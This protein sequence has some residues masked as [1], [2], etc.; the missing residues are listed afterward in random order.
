[1]NLQYVL[2]YLTRYGIWFLFLIVF[3]EYLN[4]PGFPSGIIMPAAGILIAN[5]NL[6]FLFALSVSVL[7]GLLGSLVLYSL[8]YFLGTPFVEKIYK[9][10]PKFQ[11]SI[12]KTFAYVN[13]YGA[14]ASFISRLIPVARTL[15]SLVNGIAKTNLL[16]FILFSICGI[17]IWNFAF[18]YAG[19]AFDHFFL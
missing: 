1:M 8:G 15:I 4:L 5:N 3:L 14:K 12:D 16:R 9:K 2:T 7:A 11:K 18:I 6:N 13:K 10:F 17:T 19:Y